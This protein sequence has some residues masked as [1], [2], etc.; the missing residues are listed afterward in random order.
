M[1]AQESETPI[2]ASCKLEGARIR[3]CSDLRATGLCL[4]QCLHFSLHVAGSVSLLTG[5]ITTPAG[6]WPSGQSSW[7]DLSRT[8]QLHSVLPTNSVIWGSTLKSL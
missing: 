3:G 2:T 4:S 1:E 5:F 8:F 7:V 6:M